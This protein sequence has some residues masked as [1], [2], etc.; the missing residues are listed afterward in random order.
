MYKII[1]SRKV[2]DFLD[3]KDEEFVKEKKKKIKSLENDPLSN[4]KL[5]I[6]KFKNKKNRFRL[7]IGNFKFLYEVIE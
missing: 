1:L 2:I 4:D 5:D 3:T 7:R 6:K